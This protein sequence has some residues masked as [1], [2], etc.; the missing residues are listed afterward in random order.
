MS[1]T[2]EDMEKLRDSIKLDSETVF[3]HYLTQDKEKLQIYNDALKNEK[4]INFDQATIAK[5]RK[6]FW[7]Y[8]SGLLYMYYEPTTFNNIASKVELMTYALEDKDYKIVHGSTDSTRNIKFFLYGVERLDY[9]SWIEVEEGQ[10]TWV[11]DF[12]SLLKIEK[13]VY[14]ELEHPNIFKVVPKEAIT[15]HPAY[16]SDEFRFFHDDFIEILLYQIPTME[17]NMSHHPFKEILASELVRYKRII[18]Y[19]E[20]MLKIKVENQKLKKKA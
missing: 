9:N 1:M 2:V 11:Y 6:L 16:N 7:A 15:N 13:S 20:R 18:D 14:E 3:H 4:I 8:Y 5:L 19:E 10:K 12:F 17:N